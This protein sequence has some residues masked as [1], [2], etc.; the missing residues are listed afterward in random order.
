MNRFIGT[1]TDKKGKTIVLPGAKEGYR[2]NGLTAVAGLIT[3]PFR[4]G[5]YH[6]IL[7]V[8]D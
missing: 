4:F 3:K 7:C 5:T 1:T 6:V 2:A 8:I